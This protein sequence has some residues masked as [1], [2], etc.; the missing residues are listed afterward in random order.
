MKNFFRA[1]VLSLLSAILLPPAILHAQQDMFITADSP[2]VTIGK[3]LG[4][5]TSGV[6]GINNNW[7]F[8]PLDPNEGICIYFSSNASVPENFSLV[9]YQS[10]DPSVAGFQGLQSK[11]SSVATPANFSPIFP[12]VTK[13]FFA[14]TTAAA[15]IAIVVR[16]TGS[17]PGQTVDAFLTQSSSPSGCTGGAPVGFPS[18]PLFTNSPATANINSTSS[19]PL[20]VGV[21]SGSIWVDFLPGVTGAPAS[22][23]FTI[24]SAAPGMQNG[25]SLGAVVLNVPVVASA[26]PQDF[27]F[28]FDL[29]SG[30]PAAAILAP[31]LTANFSCT[32]YPTAATMTVTGVL[33]PYRSANGIS[34]S[35]N[36]SSANGATLT[37]PS[38]Q[39]RLTNNVSGGTI[40]A[41][42]TI[43]AVA[44]TAHVL[45]CVSASM[46]QSTTPV[47]LNTR[48]IVQDG[49]V[50]IYSV[51]LAVPATT[52][53]TDHVNLCGLNIPG[54]SGNSMTCAFA[55]QGSSIFQD[56]NCSGIDVQ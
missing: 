27:V 20:P 43:N 24:R 2:Y 32:T 26:S 28:P 9:I 53:T 1:I 47:A 29:G 11:W 30:N 31:F 51:M 33:S 49:V 56:V 8:S 52:G 54:T 35:S 5:G 19:F 10:G 50:T 36:S 17:G 12:G 46:G 18:I 55:S 48:F 15:K 13:T 41:T 7:I 38:A 25:G 14:R 42:A 40:P 39:W 23:F 3:A 6:G 34:V 4:F 44:G 16:G 45:Q 21:A 37:A 22:C